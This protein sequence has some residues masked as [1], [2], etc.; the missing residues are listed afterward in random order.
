MRSVLSGWTR[1]RIPNVEGSI[2]RTTECPASISLLASREIVANASAMA[3]G[4]PPA[5]E[6]TGRGGMFVH[7]TGAAW[8]VT[9]AAMCARNANDELAAM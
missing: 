3:S 2:L 7:R 4:D 9:R 5:E 6:D 8:T 1:H